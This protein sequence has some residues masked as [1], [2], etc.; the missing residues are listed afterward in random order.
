MLMRSCAIAASIVLV[1]FHS[2][3]AAEEGMTLVEEGRGNA[4]IVVAAEASPN[5]LA[6][7]R[8]LQH[9]IREM[10]GAELPIVDDSEDVE[11]PVVLVGESRL[12]R[13]VEG[14]EVP[15]GR[16]PMLREEGYVIRC[17]DGVL[18]LAGNDTRPFLGTRYAVCELL[19]RLGVRWYMPGQFG[20]V[21]PR[22][23]TIRVP[24]MDLTDRPDFP[25]RDYWTHS[26]GDM[27]ALR[28]EWK[29]HNK[30]NPT[31]RD[32][33]PSLFAV[34][35]DG[36]I[37][38]Y[39]SNEL[40]EEHPDWFALLRDG[41]RN[42]HMVCMTSREMIHHFAEQVKE[43][44]RAGQVASAFAPPDGMPR[45]YCEGCVAMSTGFDGFDV[46]E[47][48]PWPQASTSQEWFHFVK[49]IMDE[50]NAE[51]PDHVIATNG[52]ANRDIPPDIPGLADSGNLVVMFANIAACTLHSYADEHCWQMKRQ[53]QMI[54]TW[55]EMCDKVWL[56]NYNYTMLVNKTTLT[57]MVHR[58]RANIP[59]LKQWGAWGF[60][61][62]DEPD[63]ALS[64]IPTRLVRAR[65]EWDTEADVEAVLDD[66][67][68]TWF[69]PAAMPM[70]AYYNALESA[71]ATT[72]EHG[73][74]E[75]ILPR[76][77]TDE[78]LAELE[79]SIHRAEADATAEPY[80]TRVAL[81]RLICDNIRSFTDIE[82]AKQAVSYADA[83]RHIEQMQERRARMNE[84]TPFMGWLPYG[85][86]GLEWEK[87]RLAKLQAKVSGA[88]GE[89]VAVL[90]EE[91]RF[92]TDPNDDGRYERWQRPDFDD[93][94]WRT[95]R[96]TAGWQSQGGLRAP[97]GRPYSGVAWYRMSFH[98]TESA[99][100][101]KAR[102]CGPAALSEVWV[103]VNGRYVGHRPYKLA[104]FRPH[105]FDLDI[106]DAV[107][108]GA[109]NQITIRILDNFQVF[110]ASGIYERMF[111]YAPTGEVEEGQ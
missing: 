15:S 26:Q 64:G 5:A 37:N 96:T 85:A 71:F 63:W 109:A 13:A 6:A 57:P 4:R 56:Y 51:F 7:A 104:W 48:D 22:T 52:Y 47:R 45:C 68:A 89:L 41:T 36:S 97:D 27:K 54:R 81:E 88:Q 43:R 69:G 82:K 103:W 86:Y 66:F 58:M 30:M 110:G 2:A 17:R 10:S 72:T 29:I 100:A 74:E 90:P 28:S 50:V 61:D 53:G 83:I 19:H 67:F 70:R 31:L 99:G 8:E 1:L 12:T 59:I 39:I 79:R 91:A 14:L 77:Y 33:D 16:T 76:I 46:N 49:S 107:E 44:A 24:D 42:P 3:T 94:Q 35:S 101:G 98:C 20:E 95:I 25:I 78:L 111:I 55:C 34:P 32:D 102:I 108:P 80:R 23:P 11:G 60:W 21:V 92:R 93:S 40:F 18:V 9:Y 84:I 106:S 75:I 62:Q 65:L 38:G 87:K 73:H 105:E